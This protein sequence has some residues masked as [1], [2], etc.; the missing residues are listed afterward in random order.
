MSLKKTLK[1]W[2]VAEL[3]AEKRAMTLAGRTDS[4]R[5]LV[6][7]RELSR[8]SSAEEGNRPKVAESKRKRREPARIGRQMPK[9]RRCTDLRKLTDRQLIAQAERAD[10]LARAAVQAEL[11]R[12]GLGARSPEQVERQREERHGVES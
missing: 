2:S 4:N 5:Y 1:K 3:A 12:R 8:R 6:I 9:R 11:S 7:C 10:N